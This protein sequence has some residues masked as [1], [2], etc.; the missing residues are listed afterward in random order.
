MPV[1]PFSANSQ[2]V[3]EQARDIASQAE[4]SFTTAHL[5]LAFFVMPNSAEYLLADYG[6]NEETLLSRFDSTESERNGLSTVAESRAAAFADST[7]SNA[8]FCLHLLAALTELTDGI[9][10]RLLLR[11]GVDVDQLRAVALDYLVKQT[12]LSDTQAGVSF[13]QQIVKMCQ[14]VDLLENDSTGISKRSST[15]NNTQARDTK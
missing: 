1:K 15:K 13:E 4:Q 7:G 6:I 3:M 14:I 11:T 9:A 2:K 5:L 12:N 8:I 10:F